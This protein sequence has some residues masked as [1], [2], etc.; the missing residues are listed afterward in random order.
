MYLEEIDL[1]G[2]V[3][4]VNYLKYLDRARSDYLLVLGFPVQTMIKDL[5]I[6]LVVSRITIDYICPA[7]MGEQIRVRTQTESIRGAS[8]VC[9][10]EIWN[11][12]LT[13]CYVKA[14]VKLVCVDG[15]LKPTPMPI[16]LR[17]GLESG[18]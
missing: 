18:H 11:Q 5:G 16:E 7:Q 14:S 17:R 12:N 6:N 2:V 1:L 3:Y 13:I 8:L 15:K 10:Q 4:H 9:V